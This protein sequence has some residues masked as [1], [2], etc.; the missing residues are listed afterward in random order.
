MTRPLLLFDLDGPI[1]D[2]RPRYHALHVELVEAHGGTPLDRDT[3]WALKRDQ[4]SEAA[5]VARTGLVGD[6]LAEVLRRRALAIEHA[7]YVALDEV[8]PWSRAV[9]SELGRSATLV[10]VT[11]R[12]DVPLVLRQL[13]ALKLLKSFEKVLAGPGSGPAPKVE[14][15]RDAGLVGN[16]RTV[17]IG[18]TEVDVQSGRELGVRTVATRTG[19][20]SEAKL[21][22][23]GADAVLD[24][25][26]GLPTWLEREGL[27]P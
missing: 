6:S 25:I 8:W 17:F 26:R 14:R 18:D 23:F 13:E 4:V 5:I 20:R 27:W 9:L 15:V 10:L 1:L 16:R 19:I 3:Y 7:D 21:A 24:D 2:V 11:L 12:A 22:S